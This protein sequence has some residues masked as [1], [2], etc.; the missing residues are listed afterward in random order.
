MNVLSYVQKGYL[1]PRKAGLKMTIKIT[2]LAVSLLFFCNQVIAKCGSPDLPFMSTNH[3][4]QSAYKEGSKMA[5][6][7]LGGPF[8]VSSNSNGTGKSMTCKSNQ[9]QPE[10]G[11]CSQVLYFESDR[12]FFMGSERM[13][14]S[15]LFE[16]NLENG[17][18]KII[19]DNNPNTC[20]SVAKP[21][22]WNIRF[23][24]KMLI[25]HVSL[26]ITNKAE[27]TGDFIQLSTKEGDCYEE[28]HPQMSSVPLKMKIFHCNA[29]SKTSQLNL[30]LNP[31]GQEINICDM[32]IFAAN[33]E[34]CGLPA[35]PLYSSVSILRMQDNI[36]VAEYLCKEHYALQGGSM[37]SCHDGQWLPRKAPSCVP[38]HTCYFGDKLVKDK[39]MAFKYYELDLDGNAI[40]GQSIRQYECRNNSLGLEFPLIQICRKNG[41]WSDIQGLPLCVLKLDTFLLVNTQYHRNRMLVIYT[42]GCLLVIFIAISVLVVQANRSIAKLKKEM[43]IFKYKDTRV[44]PSFISQ[45]LHD[46]KEMEAARY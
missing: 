32:D 40:A 43:N 5:L 22:T 34:D 33:L 20:V 23:S 1:R 28:S 38:I 30:K 10:G 21:I 7:C 6:R 8:I 27:Q 24:K 16:T 2:L 42:L 19:T 13:K 9:W 12:F 36:K 14:E 26:I 18:F 17:S 46:S 4:L 31:N 45:I 15:S 35:Q 25:S 37:R 39:S 44:S 3:E 41:T 29:T 11:F